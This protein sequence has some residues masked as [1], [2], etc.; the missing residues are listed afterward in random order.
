[1]LAGFAIEI[2]AINCFQSL[3]RR[4]FI[5]IIGLRRDTESGFSLR[6][7]LVVFGKVLQFLGK[8]EALFV[9]NR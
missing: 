9:F 3:C 8:H 1:M 2:F 5:F 4:K 7:R 6:L